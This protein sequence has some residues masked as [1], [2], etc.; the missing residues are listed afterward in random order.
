MRRQI[1]LAS[2]GIARFI[3]PACF[4]DPGTTDLRNIAVGGTFPR[5]AYEGPGTAAG[6]AMAWFVTLGARWPDVSDAI[7]CTQVA[8][9]TG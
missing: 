8:S 9:L 2:R 3:D 4:R 1:R 7:F 6:F 5:A